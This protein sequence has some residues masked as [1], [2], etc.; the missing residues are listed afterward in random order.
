MTQLKTTSTDTWTTTQAFALAAVSLLLGVCG[1][2]ILRRAS[3]LPSPATQQAIMAPVPVA[4]PIQAPLPDLGPMASLPSAADLKK[5]ADSEAAPLLE[6]LKNA[7]TDAGLLAKLGNIYYDAKQYPE[8]ISYYERALKS[9]P[10]DTSVRTD[11]GTAYWYNGD[12]DTAI[13]QFN[14]ALSYDPA[15]ADTLFNLGIVKWQGQKDRKGAVAAWQKL[16]D[17]NPGYAEKDK[18]QQLIARTQS[19][20]R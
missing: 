15:K 7:P 3:A 5:A 12:A 1:G 19:N 9:Q 16:L 8:A 17:S 18:V 2:W 6:Q 13:A 20:E 4:A 10:A 11:L 14:Q